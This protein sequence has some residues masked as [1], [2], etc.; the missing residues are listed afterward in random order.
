[1]L[2][3]TTK[4]QTP[5]P[6]GGGW[7]IHPK[8]W[9]L[10]S[11]F[12]IPMKL[13]KQFFC[14]SEKEGS[15]YTI[16]EIWSPIYIEGT[17]F[18][19]PSFDGTFKVEN[20]YDFTNLNQCRFTAK[21][22]KF[23]YLSGKST[24][25][26]TKVTS[27]DILPGFNG[28]LKVALPAKISDYDALFLTA[29]DVH[30]KEIYTWTRTITPACQYASALI[31]TGDGAINKEEQGDN[32][33][34]NSG[35]TKVTIDKTKGIIREIA[36]NGKRLS[37]TN[38]PRYTNEGMALD[39]VKSVTENGIEKM[40]FIF[41]QKESK[42]PSKRNIIQ[43][44]LLPSGWVEIDYSFDVGGYYDHIGITFDYPEDKVKHVKWL[45]NGPYRVWKN[46]LKGVTFNIWDKDY[47]NTITGE[48][49]TYPE[50]K[51]FH[52]NLYAADLTTDEGVIRLVAASED[53][54][55]HLFTP[56]KPV[57]RNND[58]TLGI[59][60]EGQLSILNAISP[61]G[62]KFKQANEMGPQSQQN[63]VLSSGHNE[64][65]KGKVY[66]KFIP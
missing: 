50:F 59:F 9:F 21:W 47:N 56:D 29:T 58:N 23:D 65:L 5:P 7:G 16:K 51:G 53:L 4:I 46:R 18:L 45:G 26:D 34:F 2:S 22:V 42:R 33:I 57:K 43:L 35:N 31:E 12:G 17:S 32:I 19:P 6:W 66:L 55:L 39:E 15:F 41:I 3:K 27:P 24:S 37:L 8:G 44:A 60:P 40:Q 1:M 61:V 13:K 64:P 54:Y 20:R 30:G 14:V 28:L 63:Y 25:I 36:V 52:S 38:G 62:T 49:W 10:Q 48:S 11:L